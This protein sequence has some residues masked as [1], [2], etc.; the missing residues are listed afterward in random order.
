MA[1]TIIGEI[2]D[3]AL[4]LGG[5]LKS[6]K[7]AYAVEGTLAADKSNVVLLTHGYTSSHQMMG[8]ANSE[9][10]WSGLVG[11]GR[12]IDTDRVFVVSRH[13]LGSS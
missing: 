3:L 1:E 2:G 10:S 6:V 12:A 8:S 5:T 4:E 11:P 13:M 7:L 9:G